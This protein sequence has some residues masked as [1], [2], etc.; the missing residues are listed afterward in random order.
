MVALADVERILVDEPFPDRERCAALY[1]EHFDD[2]YTLAALLVG[3]GDADDVT[4]DAFLRVF[5]R[6]RRLRSP[7]GFRAYLRR[8]VVSVALGDRR[9]RGR[10]RARAE[11]AE[12]AW[13]KAPPSNDADPDLWRA[14]QALPPRQRAVIVL[15]YWSDLSERD[16]AAALGCRPGTVKSLASAAM[17]TLRKVTADG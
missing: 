1:R 12:R 8:T 3:A 9:T 7:E 15:R 13:P 16:I 2:A 10:E 11:R 4:Q 6:L 5:S 14:V 17:A